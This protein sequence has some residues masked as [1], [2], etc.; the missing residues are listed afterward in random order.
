MIK[1]GSV[2]FLWRFVLFFV[3]I[4]DERCES[5]VEFIFVVNRFLNNNLELVIW[6]MILLICCFFK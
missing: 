1:F 6:F 2:G 3:W 4:V 5:E